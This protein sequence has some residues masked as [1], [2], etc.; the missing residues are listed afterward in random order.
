MESRYGHHTPTEVSYP[1]TT[2]DMVDSHCEI[3]WAKNSGTFWGRHP[4]ANYV[5][6]LD[7][8]ANQAIISQNHLRSNMLGLWIKNSLTTDDKR[9]VRAFRSA[10][11]LKTQDYGAVAFFAIVKMVWPNTCAG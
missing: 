2:Q 11:N 8:P 6:G 4:T 7:D 9:N 10:Y 3:L 1:F 5:T